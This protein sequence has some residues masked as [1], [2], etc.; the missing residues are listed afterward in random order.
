MFSC[1][2]LQPV[3]LAGCMLVCTTCSL[4][5]AVV[6][7]WAVCQWNLA[8]ASRLCPRRL[9]QVATLLAAASAGLHCSSGTSHHHCPSC[10]IPHRMRN[11]ERLFSACAILA[12]FVCAI[13]CILLTCFNDMAFPQASILV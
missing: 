8:G 9:S 7:A 10:R 2:K 3:A 12:G 4:L 5:S 13:A 1:S 11:R 6:V